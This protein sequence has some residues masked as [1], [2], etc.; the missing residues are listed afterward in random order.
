[1]L[2]GFCDDIMIGQAVV[3]VRPGRQGAD[4]ARGR[5]DATQEDLASTRLRQTLS[6]PGRL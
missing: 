3:W 1:M 2:N 4:Q 5:G 6:P